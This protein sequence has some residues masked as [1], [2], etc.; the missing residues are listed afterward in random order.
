[1]RAWDNHKAN[2]VEFINNRQKKDCHEEINRAFEI[3]KAE[4]EKSGSLNN[5]EI[6]DKFQL[7]EGRYKEN[8][9]EQEEKSSLKIRTLLEKE[10]ECI[11]KIKGKIG[12]GKDLKLLFDQATAIIK[13]ETEIT[14][15]LIYVFEAEEKGKVIAE[16]VKSG[17][18][19]ALG[20][21]LP[22]LIFGR[23]NSEDYGREPIEIY[24]L[25]NLN[26]YQIQ[27][28][29]SFQVKKSFAV[30]LK[31]HGKVW[32]LLVAQECEKETQWEEE[33]KALLENLAKELNLLLQEHKFGE[34]LEQQV[35]KEMSMARLMKKI[36]SKDLDIYKILKTTT[37]ETRQLLQT[38]R[39]VV[40]RFNSDWSGA[41][42]AESFALGWISIIDTQENQQGMN[43][44]EN[45]TNHRCQ[46]INITQ[47][48]SFNTD[49]Y[50]QETKGGK[51]QDTLHEKVTVVNDIYRQGYSPCYLESLEKYQAKAYIIA[52]IFQ[53][54]KLWGL[55]GVYQN[56]NPR[57]WLEKEVNLILQI[58]SQLSIALQQTEYI[59]R[60]QIQSQQL[61]KM[62]IRERKLAAMGEKMRHNLSEIAVTKILTI[63]TKEIKK[64]FM[65][66]R[67]L[68][69]GFNVDANGEYLA[70]S[71]LVGKEINSL[72]NL[73]C[74]VTLK[75]SKPEENSKNQNLI[76]ADIYQE[77][78]EDY[79]LEILQEFEI[80][81][82]IIAPIIV[83]K[84]LWGRLGI[85]MAK[86]YNWIDPEIKTLGKITE[87]ISLVLQ[88]KDYIEQVKKQSK[89]ISNRAER[90]TSFIRVLAKINQKIIDLNQKK[91]SLKAVFNSSIQEINKLLKIDRIIL[92]RDNGNGKF[93]VISESINN[94]LE[95]LK[96]MGF[97]E[98]ILQEFIN[99]RYHNL[100]VKSITKRYNLTNIE[101]ELL[102]NL[103]AKSGVIIP[104]LKGERIW[105]L[106]GGLMSDHSRSW[107]ES[108]VSLL[109]QVATQFGVAIQQSEYLEKVQAQSL[110]LSEA[111]EREREAKENLEQEAIELLT[112]V[113]PAS[114]GDLT[115]RAR[116]SNNIVG[117][118]AAAYNSTIDALREIIIQV[119]Q[120]AQQ[121]GETTNSSTTEIE[122]LASQSQK[123][124]EDIYKALAEIQEVLD[125]S[126]ETAQNAQ[127]V[128][129]AVDR[130]NETLGNGDRA[131]NQTVDSIMAIRQTV[132]ETSKRV[133]RLGDS[134]GKI[135]KVVSL[136]S[137]F[138]K[139]T[140]L[141]AL[142]AALEATRAGEYG[143]GFAVV[144]DEV[145][146]LAH[147]SAEATTEIE[148]LVQQI[149]EETQ[150]V[151]TAMD[152]GIERVMEGTNLVS[153]TRQ[154][155]ND[156]VLATEEISFLVEGITKS[157][158]TQNEKAEL[159]TKMMAQIATIANDTS[160]D[161]LRISAYF[162]EL[163]SMAQALEEKMGRFRVE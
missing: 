131:M 2:E 40:Y 142:N 118:I 21:S 82:Y 1:M 79:Q 153:Q 123:Q 37:Q 151:A 28:M 41:V 70:D 107:E 54:T 102:E 73:L 160:N 57:E 69:Y 157:S 125:A 143:K 16:S 163:L 53:E 116:V 27:L 149:Q 99:N 49:T 66:D 18:T 103:E 87:Q 5:S 94:K 65:V 159:M 63:A 154:S 61:E 91:L 67:C 147:Q 25:N 162:K 51:Y 42:I 3:I 88:E 148:N 62:A 120:A 77:N 130:A 6:K 32:G 136:I 133:K 132:A 93:Q 48:S 90:E 112:A 114:T 113:Q 117:T 155:L 39:V 84:K 80:Q 75:D 139:Q 76:V 19:P 158:T 111:V 89:I 68:V 60:L 124:L 13:Q 127:Q 31:N 45:S 52:P 9:L 30:S 43:S 95:M 119:Q 101:L 20:E 86:A 23:E 144:A 58:A 161:S 7:L 134:S 135:S 85:Y 4:L 36:Q 126:K 71:S 11:E 29:T 115:V 156:I 17:W 15:I 12:N 35:N 56:S 97:M 109:T 145:R 128:G 104:V 74:D 92:I 26:P 8:F 121:V 140:N 34:E 72:E 50:L 33:D 64:L 81:A 150:E 47:E 146:S 38:E 22:C 152:L 46:I 96:E 108:E 83:G 98:N 110:E 141:L 106:L 24:F 44:S 100:V 129:L 137:D 105:G 10:R 78:L 138:A 55:L 122:G 14:R 59:Q